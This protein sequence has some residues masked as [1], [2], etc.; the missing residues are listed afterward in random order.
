MA[1]DALEAASPAT[2]PTGLIGRLI[3]HWQARLEEHSRLR[4]W[5]I[6]LAA[7]AAGALSALAMPDTYA[8]PLLLVTIPFL[9]WL[10]D[11]SA[12]LGQAF[13]RGWFFGFGHFV[14]GLYWIGNAVLNESVDAAW[15]WPFAVAGLPAVVAVYIGL[16]ALATLWLIR[17]GWR[18]IPALALCWTVAELLR[19]WLFTGFPWNLMGS[20]WTVFDATAQPAWLIGTYGLSF[21]TM[22]VAGAPYALRGG[23]RLWKSWA[24]L[25]AAV[26][27]VGAMAGF[28]QWRL[29]THPTEYNPDIKLRIVQADI[30]QNQKWDPALQDDN[31]LTYLRLSGENARDVTAFIWPETALPYAI[32]DDPARQHLIGRFL[33]EG[34]MLITGAP[35]VERRN[36]VVTGL[37][38]SLYLLGSNGRVEGVYDKMHLVPFGEYLPLRPL[39]APFGVDKLVF[40]PLDYSP[41]TARP[42]LH[43]EGLPP[44]RP[45]ICYEVIFPG[46]VEG[47]GGRADWLVNIT[48]DSWYGDTSGPRQHLM[49][50]KL[51]AIEEGLPIARAAGSGISAYFDAYGRRLASLEFDHRGTLDSFLPLPAAK[52]PFASTGNA[53]L[54]VMMLCVLVFTRRTRTFKLI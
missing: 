42:L 17:R 18:A 50:A 44:F 1:E 39:F 15:A 11:G 34:T 46:H 32:G 6:A 14:V 51:R 52:G 23:P 43:A 49:A 30:P 45:L 33:P 54:Y 7:W 36:G 8:L 24:P 4:G 10:I 47:P 38:N 9:L 37:W 27:L 40:G 41:G 48:N 22:L 5:L 25:G 20:I 28:G 13:R 3:G 29:A 2:R 53:I 35:R 31:F 21:V 26:L 19:G 16:A 12:S